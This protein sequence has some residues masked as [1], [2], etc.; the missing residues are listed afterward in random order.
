MNNKIY[1]QTDKKYL[2]ESLSFIGFR[3]YKFNNDKTTN[4][5][6]YAFDNTKELRA[7]IEE[8][9]SLRKKYNFQNMNI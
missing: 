4:V 6:T 8:I 7:A 9:M 2:A 1:Y 5:M 3:Y